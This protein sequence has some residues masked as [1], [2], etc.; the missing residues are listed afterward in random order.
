MRRVLRG[1]SAAAVA[2]GSGCR[3]PF[4]LLLVVL[5]G[6]CAKKGA[7]AE[8]CEPVSSFEETS[9]SEEHVS[10]R[11]VDRTP[12]RALGPRSFF[13]LRAEGFLPASLLLPSGPPPEAGFRVLFLAHGAGGSGMEH[14][15]YWDP[16]FPLDVLFVCPTGALLN[17]GEPEGGAYFPDHLKL[18]AELQALVLALRARMGADLSPRDWTYMG[19]SQGATMGALA[20]VGEMT[21][22]ARLILIE[23]GAE[24]WTTSRAQQFR[25]GGG[26]SVLLACGT[27]GCATHGRRSLVAL[28]GAD[29]EA[30]HLHVTGG[31][32]T[33]GGSVGHALHERL[34]KWGYASP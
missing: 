31:G 34:I 20:I 22:F 2:H 25:E 8:T 23:G 19:Y 14:C 18:R 24:N 9:S 15:T 7:E 13:E 6:A 27:K 1:E 29:L 33:Y 3:A 28:E 17:R 32:H 5:L 10:D 16:Y 11:P 4:W 30:A 12:P 26:Q 21:D